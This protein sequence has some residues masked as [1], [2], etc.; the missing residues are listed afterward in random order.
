MKNDPFQMATDGLVNW[1]SYRALNYQAEMM[2]SSV[3]FYLFAY[4]GT[5][6][7]T[8]ANGIPRRHGKIIDSL[9]DFSKQNYFRSF[10]YQI[11]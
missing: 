6:S 1:S 4:E 8:Y 11:S 7:S 5:F 3:Y 2:N 10:R 9:F